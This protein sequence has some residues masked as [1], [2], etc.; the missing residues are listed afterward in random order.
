ML[1]PYDYG[2]IAFYFVFM[3]AIGVVFKNFIG[4][5]SDYF[6]GG[7]QMLWWMTGSSA[8]MVQ[9][10]AWTFTG[11]ASKAYSDGW[12]ILIL[13]FANALGF[14]MNYLYFAAKFR[15]MRVITPIQA[16]RSR[17]GKA[18]E[19]FF[20]WLQIPMS[21]L[22]AAIWL[23]GLGIFFSAVFG[24]DLKTTI[25]VT[26]GVVLILS[27]LGGSWAVVASDFMQVLILMPI[28]VVVAV[29]ALGRVGGPVNLVRDFPSDNFAGSGMNYTAIFFVWIVAI[30]IK[31]FIST[32]NMLDASRY[33]CAKDSDHAR[34]GAL[35]AGSLFLIGPVIWFIPPMAAA[36]LYPDLASIFPNL[37]RPSEASYVAMASTVLPIGMMGLLASGIFAATMSSM[38]SGLNRNAGIFVKNFY[39]SVL[40]PKASEKELLLTGKLV[41]LVLGGLI[42]IAA[43]EFS[44]MKGIGLFDLMLQFGALVALPYSIPLVLGMFVRGTPDWAGWTTVLI[45]FCASLVGKFVIN[46]DWLVRTFGLEPLTGREIADYSL[47]VGVLLNLVVG[48]TW[49]LLSRKFYLHHKEERDA[50]VSQFF[51]DLGRPIDF[52]AEIGKSK[53]SQ[54]GGALGNLAMIYGGFICLLILIPN[55]LGGRIAFLFTGGF[56]VLIGVLLKRGGNKSKADEA[57]AAGR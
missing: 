51:N 7:G 52:E 45:G 20:T 29:L 13:F 21:T 55:P 1:T 3:L 44:K 46:A 48:V 49:F 54:Q 26:G 53:D 23:N 39:E 33:L 4:N 38:D 9:F 41:T 57:A 6:R 32:N 8:F 27:L 47:A 10:S 35:L 56:L 16:V 19:Q 5:T 22:Y 12:V 31:Q 40:R 42:L 25:L 30:I 15:Q 18:N 24:L 36:I 34:K 50:E 28:S 17:F 43:L 11:G 14:L 37:D 2:V